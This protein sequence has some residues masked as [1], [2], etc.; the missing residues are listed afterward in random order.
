MA[1]TVTATSAEHGYQ[2][3]TDYITDPARDT[4]AHAHAAAAVP[5]AARASA[6]CTLYA[7]LDAHVNG[8]GGG[9]DRQRAAP[10]PA[11]S[12]P[13]R[14]PG[15][16]RR[17][18]EHGQPAPPTATTRCR[19]TWRCGQPPVRR[20]PA[21]ATPG[22]A[23]DGLT[24]L[25]GDP[26]ARPPYASAPDGHI[27]ADRAGHARPAAARV[28]LAL[29]FGRTQAGA[30]GHGA[31]AR[32]TA[33]R[34]TGHAYAAGWAAYD[35]RAAAAAGSPGLTAAQAQALDLH[36]YL[37]ANVLK[38]SE[39][40][41]FP[42]AIVAS[43]AS[44][45]G[46]AV[47]RRRPARRQAGLLR[48]LPRGV[49]PRPV[50][51]VHRPARR[52]RPGH[53]AGRDPVPVRPPAAG[54]RAACRAT[55]C[56]TARPRRTPAATSWTRRVPDPDGLPV[57]AWRGRRRSTRTT[58]GRRPTSWSRTG[59]SFG[60]ERWEEQRGYS[61]STIAAEIAGLTA[62]AAI[63]E[64]PRRRRAAR[65]LYQATA[66]DFQRTIKGWTV[67]TTGPYSAA[68]YFI[69]LS[70][71]GDPNAAITYNLGNGGPTLD[72]RAVIDGGFQELVRLGELP[73]ERPRRAGLAGRAGQADRGRHADRHRLLPVR[74]VGRRGSA[75]GYGDCYAP[76][77]TT[78]TTDGQ[79]WPTTDIGTGHLWPVLSGERA[80]TDVADRRHV[81][82]RPRCSTFM[83]DSA[84]GVGL[85][86]EQAW[87]DPD[88]A[89]SP[90]GSDPTT[91]SIG[92]TDG[93]AGRLGLAA[94]LGP[95]AGAA[96]DRWTSAPAGPS[97]A[98]RSPPTATSTHGAAGARR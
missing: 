71:T 12:T 30:V 53:R 24:Q 76:S 60:N 31:G 43:L 47:Q 64:R 49:R 69:R 42:G 66:D 38:A 95:G 85:V 39:D 7:R 67:T 63:A 15:A 92:F 4:R 50:R 3:V 97:T 74:H 37:S 52:R 32:C 48:L 81:R 80:E 1:C 70:K 54:R 16:G 36:Y 17:Q 34:A 44:P 94:D 98:R 29:G 8:N 72:Q 61:P 62:A 83:L 10:T 51:G 20:R 82:A 77:Q 75:D 78:C 93:K 65:R 6:G 5:G 89:A 87:E 28:T 25:D 59:P 91:A 11:S 57:R 45:W 41:T 22:T 40:K 21:S 33:V 58:S 96:A 79:P 56:S 14:R 2:L 27:V 84:S 23:S 35:A 9:G 86:P 90:Y 68:P 88:L 18:H 19:P 46:Q 55:R 73:A 26:R 13:H